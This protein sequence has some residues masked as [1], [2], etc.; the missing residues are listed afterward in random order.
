M[1]S[2]VCRP[3]W[4]QMHLICQPTC[5]WAKLFLVWNLGQ[6]SIVHILNFTITKLTG[7]F[8]SITLSLHLL[9]LLTVVLHSIS[10]YSF[11]TIVQLVCLRLFFENCSST[12]LLICCTNFKATWQFI[13]HFTNYFCWVCL[14]LPTLSYPFPALH[15]GSHRS[16]QGRLPPRRQHSTVVWF[17]SSGDK[18]WRCAINI[19]VHVSYPY[20]L[21][22]FCLIWEWWWIADNSLEDMHGTRT[23]VMHRALWTSEQWRN[24]RL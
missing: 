9:C 13:N 5:C 1:T 22:T 6:D 14:G 24:E 21:S 12:P 7:S 23:C 20:F 15:V 11:D 18:P 2:W 19:P 8:L 3:L 17:H 10:M 4:N 16:D